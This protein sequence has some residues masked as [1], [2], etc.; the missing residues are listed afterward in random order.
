MAGKKGTPIFSSR[1]DA[2]FREALKL[3]DSKQYKKALKLVEANLKKNSS[4]SESIALKG[5]C[6]YHTGNQDE[7]EAYI[8]KAVQ[9]SPENYLVDHLAGIYYRSVENYEEAAKWLKQ[10]NDNGSPN[11]PILRDLSFM[12]TQIRDYK[13]LK[14]SRQQYLENQPGFRANWTGV[15]VALHLNK[16]YSNAVSTLVKI[17]GI[18]K[19]YLT[20]ADRYEQSECVLYKNSIIAESGDISKALETLESDKDEIR[21]GLS[22]LEYKAKYLLMLGKN[23]EASVEYRKLLQ[24]NPD[25]VGYYNLLE[26]SLGSISKPIDTRIKLYNRLSK[27]YPKSDPPKFLPLTFVPGSHESFK[28]LAKAYIL[29]QLRR[30][31]PATFVNV[32]PLYKNHKKLKAIESIVLEFFEN[33]I[34]QLD[35]TVFVWT[36]YFLAQHYLYLNDLKSAS[37][38]IDD[39]INHSPTLVELYIIKAKILKHQKEYIKASEIMN[40][41]RE[42]DLQDRFINTKATKYYFRANKVDEA[43][44]CISLFTKIEDGS[45]NGNKDLHL[46]QANWALVETAE[47]YT[48]LYHEYQSK[49]SELKESEESNEEVEKELGENIELYRGLALK[50]YNWIIKIFKT[51]YN[52]QYD[53]HSYCMRRGTPRDYIET[54]KWEDKIHTTPIYIRVLKGLSNIY[55]ELYNEQLLAKAEEEDDSSATKKQ[56]NKKQK[57]VKAQANKKRSELI[58][59]VE[60][61]KDDTDPLGQ[62]VVS[63]LLDSDIIESLFVL[64]KP[65][66]DE[67]KDLRLTWEVLFKIYLIQGKYVLAL[68]AIKNLNR[69]LSRNEPIKLAS[70][71]TRVIELSD[72]LAKDNNVNVAIAKVVEKGINSAFPEFEQLSKSEF[73]QI[74]SK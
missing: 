9:K 31:V 71:G 65:L 42:L 67:G 13:N 34:K 39:A 29:P 32:K 50:R 47:A 26:V 68:Q 22:F 36:K 35:P 73:L 6:Y 60:A 63:D 49:L 24:R 18:I 54:L 5:C 61:E 8:L 3:F 56:K 51:Y 12:Q 17:E 48:R 11:K 53:F 62:K 28:D 74:Y 70:I 1:E 23:Q 58:A 52:D 57:K 19:D 43:I 69:I 44:E 14:D 10:S 45:V 33:D 38:H 20:E 30:G 4:H 7:A 25:N 66:I 27:F 64:I 16:E 41:G 40:E 2:N 55:F 21:D 15:A 72:T 37:T 59:K 46:M